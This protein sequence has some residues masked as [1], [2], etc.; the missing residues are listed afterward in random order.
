MTRE[1]L[2][3]S[4]A[5]DP[6]LMPLYVRVLYAAGMNGSDEVLLAMGKL[7]GVAA[8]AASRQDTGQV[9]EAELVMKA[10]QD[11][12]THH[13][14]LLAALATE[15]SPLEADEDTGGPPYLPEAM[16]QLFPRL[17]SEIVDLCLLNLASSGLA[18]TERLW[19]G[20]AY[21]VTDLGRAV[22]RAAEVMAAE[23]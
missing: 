9:D 22:L 23:Q 17:R 19:G 13:F 2:A 12:G 10:L 7:L 11:L 5:A 20:D 8:D 16:K 18:G 15:R 1:D 21:R 4:L 6:K 14:V 3:E